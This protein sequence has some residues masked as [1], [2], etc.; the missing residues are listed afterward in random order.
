MKAPSILSIQILI[1]IILFLVLIPKVYRIYNYEDFLEPICCSST[2]DLEKLGFTLKKEN[3]DI[4]DS[5]QSSNSKKF[6]YTFDHGF[7]LA[8]II[9]ALWFLVVY[10][11]KGI[12][13]SLVSLANCWLALG[14]FSIY[15]QSIKISGENN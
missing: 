10:R 5:S 13:W 3:S 9:I 11:I 6:W 8:S 14:I 7:D 2:Q 15:L 4:I 12:I 1:A